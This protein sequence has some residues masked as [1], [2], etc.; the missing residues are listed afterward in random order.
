MNKKTKALTTEQ[1]KEIIQTMKE[2]FCSCRP[3]ERIATAL[4]MEGNLGLRISDII[5][6]APVTLFGM[7]TASALRSWNRRPASAVSL[8]SRW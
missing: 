6:P 5:K 7:V 4:V 8:P 3:N 1:Y 2:G